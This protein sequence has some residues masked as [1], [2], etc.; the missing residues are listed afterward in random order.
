MLA[1]SS[2]TGEPG[3]G[4]PVSTVLLLAGLPLTLSGVAIRFGQP[5]DGSS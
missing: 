1:G 3:R 2:H 4:S 5:E